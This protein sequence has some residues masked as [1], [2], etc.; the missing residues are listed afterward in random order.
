MKGIRMMGA[1]LA[2][3]FM[4]GSAAAMAAGLQTVHVGIADA[5][6]DV[7]FFIADKKGYFRA[8]GIDAKFIPF[9]SGAKMVAP[10]AVAAAGQMFTDA[11]GMQPH[12]TPAAMT[13]GELKSTIGEYAQAAKN[14]VAAGFDGVELHGANG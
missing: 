5:S 8:E 14:A 12:P 1:A 2:V 4:L 6:S 3:C 11:Q 13:E 9:D 7:V 10:S